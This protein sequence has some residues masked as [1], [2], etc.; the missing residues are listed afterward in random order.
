MI[1]IITSYQTFMFFDLSQIRKNMKF[2]GI[3]IISDIDGGYLGTMSGVIY[4]VIIA[5]FFP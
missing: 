4:L 3:E 5:L 1:E 2:K